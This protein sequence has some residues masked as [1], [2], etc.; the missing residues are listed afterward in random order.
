MKIPNFTGE[1]GDFRYAAWWQSV[2]QDDAMTL[3]CC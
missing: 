2:G 3:F 1:V